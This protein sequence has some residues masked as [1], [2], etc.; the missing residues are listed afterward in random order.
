MNVL[1]N[2]Y[3]TG[4]AENEKNLR[5]WQQ[6][7][8]NLRSVDFNVYADK[9][10]VPVLV[11]IGS[12]I[13]FRGVIKHTNEVT[14]ALGADYFTKCSVKQAEVLRDHRM[15][16]AQA[17][18][19]AL[20]K[21]KE[22]LESQLSFNKQNV[23][24]VSGHEIVEEYNEAEDKL[25]REKHRQNMKNYIQ[26]KAKT[27]DVNET[28]VTDEEL[29]ERL[30]ELELQEELENEMQNMNVVEKTE[31]C[32]NSSARI[33][34]DNNA[35]VEINKGS[36]HNHDHMVTT[37]DSS[38]IQDIEKSKYNLIQKVLEKQQELEEKLFE[39]K[40]KERGQSKT[41]NDLLAKLDEME[42]LDEL[43]DEMDRLDNLLE[44]GN[45]EDDDEEEEGIDGK[46]D[47]KRPEK[48]KRSTSFADEDDSE[49]LELTFKHSDTS[50]NTDPYD[51]KKGIMKPSDLYEA[52]KNNFTTKTS[53]LKKSKYNSDITI[54]DGKKSV[55]FADAAASKEI[56]EIQEEK[57]TILI[58][59]IQE[60]KNDDI[61]TLENSGRPISLFKMR[62]QQNKK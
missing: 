38:H 33:E 20:I 8:H 10:K 36:H 43:E 5:Y 57:K 6:Y 13:L 34:P 55:A 50:P 15:K 37:E 26:N 23:V 19:N 47:V 52:Y 48:I 58:K 45:I 21:E 42:E 18:V 22:Y 31:V 49:C 44:N 61:S 24:D 56:R 53:I 35:L 1:D 14:A 12:R 60:K 39:L 3:Y 2:I 25:W 54:P 27:N 4:L 30:E 9:L 40:H 17:K 11:P 41:E 32:D 29:W 51:P 59:D 46:E 7:L 16:D 28:N 62:R